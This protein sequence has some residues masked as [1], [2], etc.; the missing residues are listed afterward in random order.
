MAHSACW[1]LAETSWKILF[2]LNCCERKILFQLKKQAKQAGFWVS[3]FL[4]E[5]Y[6]SNLYLFKLKV[7]HFLESNHDTFCRKRVDWRMTDTTIQ[8]WN[9][10]ERLY[11]IAFCYHFSFFFTITELVFFIYNLSL[12]HDT[13]F[14]SII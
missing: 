8:D 14:R 12:S 10:H 4:R 7:L 11:R 9:A 13:A 5:K 3:Q 2:W 1:N 6:Y